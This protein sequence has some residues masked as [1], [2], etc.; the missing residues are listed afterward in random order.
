MAFLIKQ[1]DT[2]QSQ[3]DIWAPS[4]NLTNMNSAAEILGE[5][6]DG[7][8]GLVSVPFIVPVCDNYIK[9]RCHY[10]GPQGTKCDKL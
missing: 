5:M 6:F 9:Q 10:L 3:D 2:K 8:D 4:L 7:D 1:S